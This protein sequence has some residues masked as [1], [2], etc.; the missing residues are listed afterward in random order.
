M[1]GVRKHI[2]AATEAALWVLSNGQCYAPGCVSQVVVEVRLGVPR[3]NAQ[4]AHIRGVSRPRYDA[5]L[6]AEE[7]AAFRNLLLL[8]LPHHSEVDDPKTGEKLYPP[9]VLY[10]WKTDHEGSNGPALATLGAVDEETLTELL[11]GVFAPPIERLQQIADQLENT[12]TLT[13]ETVAELQQ[14]VKVMRTMPAGPDRAVAGALVD[15][16]TIYSKLDLNKAALGLMEAA[17]LLGS[18]VKELRGAANA[19]SDASY[20]RRRYE[21]G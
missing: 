2:S 18:R 17:T 20:G 9:E 11:V 6:T 3:K 16:A 10:K 7:C 1:A 15:A 14:V 13:A 12:G 5:T 19:I 21:Q 8:C 4:I